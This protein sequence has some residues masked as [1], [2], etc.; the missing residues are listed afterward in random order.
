MPG[1]GGLFKP[2]SDT[3]QIAFPLVGRHFRPCTDPPLLVAGRRDVLGA[4]NVCLKYE[5]SA[6]A[7]DGLR[8]AMWVEEGLSPA[9]R[10]RPLPCEYAAG[11]VASGTTHFA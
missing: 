9:G 11:L 5:R 10:H 1:W 7:R 4:A 3:I 2:P 6:A 8:I